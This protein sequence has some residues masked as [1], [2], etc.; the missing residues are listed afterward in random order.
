MPL[1]YIRE[2]FDQGPPQHLR[3]WKILFGW[4]AFEL[5]TCCWISTGSHKT[6]SMSKYGLHRCVLPLSSEM[7]V[8]DYNCCHEIDIHETKISPDR[9]LMTWTTYQ[10]ERNMAHSL[11]SQA[12]CTGACRPFH[13]VKDGRSRPRSPN[14]SSNKPGRYFKLLGIRS[15][16]GEVTADVPK[17]CELDSSRAALRRDENICGGRATVICERKPCRGGVRC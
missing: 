10:P 17:I 13:G 12:P 9:T 5:C 15:R 14:C 1:A 3:I 6:A 4:T 11:R 7:K 8:W 2:S 16:R